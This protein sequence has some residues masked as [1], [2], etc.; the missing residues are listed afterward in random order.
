MGKL[1]LLAPLTIT[2][3]APRR[4]RTR[5]HPKGFTREQL[6]TEPDF[7]RPAAQGFNR[8]PLV[9]ETFVGY[10]GYDTVR[11][12]EPKLRPTRGRSEP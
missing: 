4:A 9:L 10:F 3:R 1:A 2:A 8:V 7:S 11:Y 5:Q 6:M 12:V